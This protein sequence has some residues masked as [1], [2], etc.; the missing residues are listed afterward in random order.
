MFLTMGATVVGAG[1]KFSNLVAIGHGTR[2]GQ[3]CLMVAQSGI[4]GSTMVGNYCVFAGQA[5][6]VGHIRI[7][8]GAR[9]GAKAGVTSDVAPRQEVLGIPAIPLPDARRAM[10]SW[11]RLPQPR[12]AVRTLTREV[13]ALRNRLGLREDEDADADATACG[14][15]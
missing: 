5:G 12:K 9:V 8:D 10:M 6:V 4:A 7:G 3:H 11:S 2:M 1:T 14:D 13:K 15:D